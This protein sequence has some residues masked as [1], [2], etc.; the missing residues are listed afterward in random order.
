MEFKIRFTKCNKCGFVVGKIYDVK[1]G[2]LVDETGYIFTVWSEQGK[3]DGIEALKSWFENS[4]CEIELVKEGFFI[5]DLKDGMVAHQ[6]NG[7]Q[8]TI[9]DNG[10]R[11]FDNFSINTYPTETLFTAKRELNTNIVKITY[12]GEVVWEI[13]KEYMTLEQAYDTGKKIKHKDCDTY[14]SSPQNALTHA[15]GIT[16]KNMFEL[17]KVKEFEIEES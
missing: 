13:K 5:S 12:M 2:Q 3:G 8:K 10:K 9:F 11:Y 1:D 15:I 7:F 14:Y 17:L 16:N 4:H 6:N